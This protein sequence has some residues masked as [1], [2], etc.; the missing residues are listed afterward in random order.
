MVD[1]I[2]SPIPDIPH[3]W[4]SLFP[5]KDVST[6]FLL[7]DNGFYL[8]KQTLPEGKVCKVLCSRRFQWR[9][10]IPIASHFHLHPKRLRQLITNDMVMGLHLQ[11][12]WSFEGG[13][14]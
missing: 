12:H 5:M 10:L 11:A 6:R 13:T 8:I 14:A 3:G 7:P 1:L 9:E 4:M 2:I